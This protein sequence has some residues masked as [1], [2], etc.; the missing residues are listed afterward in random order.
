MST[1]RKK[2]LIPPSLRARIIECVLVAAAIGFTPP[3]LAEG[4]S[5]EHPGP[6]VRHTIT[7]Q[8]GLGI[9]GDVVL[10]L[11]VQDRL[12]RQSWATCP[13]LEKDAD[14]V[15]ASALNL[16]RDSIQGMIEVA[17]SLPVRSG[18]IVAHVGEYRLDLRKENNRWRGTYT[19]WLAR[20]GRLVVESEEY[21]IT[22]A[23]MRWATYGEALNGKVEGAVRPL[24]REAGTVAALHAGR[25]LKGLPAA[26]LGNVHF[27]I[28]FRNGRSTAVTIKHPCDPDYPR[29][30]WYRRPSRSTR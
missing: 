17:V 21:F 19:G 15:H 27:S 23:D 30:V 14:Y 7:L 3:S 13:A 22:P 11:G 5:V 9:H 10:H 4:A 29:W 6:Y 25:L 28:T 20:R 1:Q 24:A 26:G 12:I 16:A 2:R 8:R 18:D